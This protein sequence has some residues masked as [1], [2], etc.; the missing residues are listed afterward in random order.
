[1]TLEEQAHWRQKDERPLG[2][3]L[4]ESCWEAFSK[5]MEIIKA[6]RWAY[7]PSHRGMFDQEGSY[8]LTSIFKVM[9]QETNLLNVEIHKVQEGGN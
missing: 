9:A 2:R 5:D 8:V 3:P 1:M 7:H 4:K 6:A